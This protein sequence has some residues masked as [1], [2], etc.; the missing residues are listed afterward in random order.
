MQLFPIRPQE[1]RSGNRKRNSRLVACWAAASA[2]LLGIHP[3]TAAT[4]T[5]STLNRTTQLSGVFSF[6]G[7]I[8]VLLAVGDV[9]SMEVTATGGNVVTLALSNSSTTATGNAP[10][11]ISVTSG[12]AGLTAVRS[13]VASNGAVITSGTVRLSCSSGGST[14]GGAA[15]AAQTSA[16]AQAAVT[17]GQI[18]VQNYADRIAKAVMGSFG[19][20]AG[21]PPAS[22]ATSARAR[23]EELIRTERAQ[24]DELGELQSKGATSPAAGDPARLAMLEQTLAATRRNLAL[25]REAAPARTFGGFVQQPDA[26]SARGPAERQGQAQIGA[27]QTAAAPSVV[28]FD[29]QDLIGFCAAG[30]DPHG[31]CDG[32]G[33]KW[34]AWTEA[35]VIGGSDSL[36]R[37]RALGFIASGGV[38]YKFLPWLAA[39]LTLGVE[40]FA[41]QFGTAGVGLNTLGFSAVPYLG[42][43]LSESI[44]ASAFAGVSTINYNTTPAVGVSAAFNATRLFLG[45]SVIGNWHYG[46]WRFQP[47]LTGTVGT[48]MQNG[49]VDSIGNEVSGQSASFGRILLGPEIGYSITSVEHGWALEPF[50]LARIG[51]DFASSTVAVTNGQSVIVRPGT[52]GFGGLG[53]GVAMQLQNGGYFRGQGSYDSIGVSGLNLW[54]VVLR[55]GI[56]F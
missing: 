18:T 27:P 39:G 30:D 17:Y 2:V 52:L 22:A 3:A 40:N 24:A 21:G 46:A 36:T 15:P 35:R 37:S 41:S 54:S 32:F 25:A 11:T 44:Y 42:F 12:A 20:M 9:V 56:A 45:A 53:G 14:D 38:D 19:L 26:A 13:T 6:T 48:E 43:R 34:N 5:C 16:N 55:A 33:A 31:S 29:T 47:A 4:S 8:Q 23:V 7:S 1:G 10:T 51:V 50:V 49:Y 28:K